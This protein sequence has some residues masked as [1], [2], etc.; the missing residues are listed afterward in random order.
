LCPFGIIYKII[1]GIEVITETGHGANNLPHEDSND[2]EMQ[3]AH[4]IFT[5]HY[6]E[7]VTSD[8]LQ[9]RFVLRQQCDM[10]IPH[11]Y[12]PSGYLP[13]ASNKDDN[14]TAKKMAH[15]MHGV[16]LVVLIFL[17]TEKHKN[18]L[19]EKLALMC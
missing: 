16:L 14:S 9:I 19:Q 1:A 8:F 7:I 2:T 10:D 4:L 6:K 13:N 5:G 12:F 18:H 3:K 15:K 11:T 17:L